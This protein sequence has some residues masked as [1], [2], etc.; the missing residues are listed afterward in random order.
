M[1][2]TLP[3]PA[4]M[5]RLAFLFLLAMP[6]QLLLAQTSARTAL[7]N[8]IQYIQYGCRQVE[9]M[10]DQLNEWYPKMLKAAESAGRNPLMAYHCPFNDE[11]FY[12]Q[13]AQTNSGAQ[14]RQLM[15][16]SEAFQQALEAVEQSCQA[17]E[18]YFKLETYRTDQFG[19]AL[20]L[21][22]QM[23]DLVARFSTA[24]QA[25][26]QQ[27]AALWP[28]PKSPAAYRVADEQLR[29]IMALQREVWTELQFNFNVQVHSGWPRKAVLTHLT[30]LQDALE[31]IERHPP[32][33]A[34][35]AS[36]Y[37]KSGI[38]C[39]RTFL[40]IERN[41]AD[42]YTVAAQENDRHA[43]DFYRQCLNLYNNCLVPLYTDAA[44]QAG[45]MALYWAPAVPACGY[46]NTAVPPDKT[47]YP[48]QDQSTSPLSVTRQQQPISPATAMALNTTIQW[49]NTCAQRNHFLLMA[50]V[51]NGLHYQPF[52][53][54]NGL[55]FNFDTYELPWSLLMETERQLRQL[56]ESWRQPLLQQAQQLMDICREMDGQR[57]YLLDFSKEKRWQQEGFRPVEASRDRLVTLFALFDQKKEHLYADIV[58]IYDAFP[59]PATA[60]NNSW[61]R[62][63]KALTQVVQADK[64]LCTN[65]LSQW[66]QQKKLLNLPHEAVENAAVKSIQDEFVNLKG[67]EKLGRYN[68]LCPYSPYEDIGVTSRRLAEYGRAPERKKTSDFTYLY[69]EIV[70]EYNRFVELSG[71]PFLKNTRLMDLFLLETPPAQRHNTAPASPPV[72]PPVAAE[73]PLPRADVNRRDTIYIRDTIYLEKPPAVGDNFYSLEGY[74]DNNLVLLLDVSGS[75]KTEG[76]LPLLQSAIGRLVQLLRTQDDI[77]VVGFSGKGQV[78]LPPTSGTDK[79]RILNI[80]DALK[81]IGGTN[82]EAGLKMAFQTARQ[83]FKK[84]G[85]NRIILATDGDFTLNATTLEQIRQHAEVGI[86]LSVF[87][88]GSKPGHNLKAIS[89]NGRGNLISITP[90]NAE[91][92]MIREA[93]Q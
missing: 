23:P 41:F 4:L 79:T 34:Y 15:A 89:E 69:N 80:I 77:A 48:F 87:K 40:E 17:L 2:Y 52:P 74:A 84:N 22:R 58:R 72:T 8:Q 25:Y 67:I 76:R 81:P 31:D 86:S 28:T 61:Q 50:L 91:I 46:T 6:S 85:N 12:R 55:F 65:V 37:Y 35:P 13:Q 33:L 1:T 92:F 16:A 5:Y 32:Q 3:F 57:Q 93:Q 70:E 7:N 43:N 62:S 54:K 47:I 9:R 19:G 18:T 53:E 45:W 66:T 64:N 75:M 63:Y 44:V 56:P 20:A 21:M 78:L 73:K 49:I 29:R 59:V 27:T 14:G 11:P 82:I 42:E 60:P 51:N 30:R 24:K 71:Q 38:S 36:S 68:G 10:V 39:V 26:E 83:N 88:F 90:E